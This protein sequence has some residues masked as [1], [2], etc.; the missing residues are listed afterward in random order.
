MMLNKNMTSEN[1]YLSI[2]EVKK[3]TLAAKRLYLSQKWPII[4]VTRRSIEETAAATIIQ[5]Y[6]YHDS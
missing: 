1:S 4:D 6:N 5:K 2:D 3:E